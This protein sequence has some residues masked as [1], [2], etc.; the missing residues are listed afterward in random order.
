MPGS[1]G[2]SVLKNPPASAGDMA[3]IPG[4][5]MSPGGGNGNPLQYSCLETWRIPWTEEPA[6][7]TKELDSTKHEQEKLVQEMALS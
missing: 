5:R 1:P 6:G 7:C 3:S 4:S 2:G